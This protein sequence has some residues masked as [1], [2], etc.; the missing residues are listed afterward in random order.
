[1][2]SMAIPFTTCGEAYERLHYQKEMWVR[3][4]ECGLV[5]YEADAKELE[6][7]APPEEWRV[8][9]YVGGCIHQLIPTA[10]SMEYAVLGKLGKVDPEAAKYDT[11]DEYA[12]SLRTT[13]YK[14]AVEHSRNEPT[15]CGK[16]YAT[17]LYVQSPVQIGTPEHSMYGLTQVAIPEEWVYAREV[18]VLG[19]CHFTPRVCADPNPFG[20]DSCRRMRVRTA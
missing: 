19:V 14:Y 6:A 18:K 8:V 20:V 5:L 2:Y 9:S 7:K 16:Y 13:W 3:P 11:F 10:S 15:Q 1:M 12:R 17:V 4:V